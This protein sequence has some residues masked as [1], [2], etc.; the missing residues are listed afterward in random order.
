MNDHERTRRIV[1]SA[2]LDDFD[3]FSPDEMGTILYSPFAEKCAVRIRSQMDNQ[4]LDQ[5][6]IFQIARH[7]KRSK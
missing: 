6:P 2:P 1:N 7:L 4:V 5:S 3:G